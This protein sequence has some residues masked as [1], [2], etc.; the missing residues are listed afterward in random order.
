[1]NPIHKLL[2]A[3]RGEIAVRI[4]RACRE[5]DIRSVAVYSEADKQAL[6]VRMADEAVAIGPAPASESYLN[7]GRVVDAAR[8][9]H[10]DAIHPGYG[11]LSE[12][13]AFAQAVGD[14]GLIF[15]GPSPAAIHA[16][17]DKVEARSRMQARGVPVVP[18]YQDASDDASL[19]RAA[20]RIGYPVLI[21]AA[22]G[23][24]GKA[25]QV[26]REE[27]ELAE[28]AASARREAKN[29]FG[30]ERLFLEKYVSNGRHVEFQV[31]ADSHGNTL[32]LF[33][34]EC[35][36]Q[37]RHQKIIEETPSPLL[38]VDL[39]AQM[40]AAAV[41]AARA[42][43]YENAGT[44]EFIVDP[45]TRAFYFLEMNTRLQVEHPITEMVTGLDLVHWQIR[46]A[47]GE[48]L[49]FAQ[50]DLS[51]RGHAVECRVYAE[52]PANQFLPSIGCLLKVVEP[53]GP[54]IRVDSGITTGDEV[55]TY[56]DPMLAKVIVHAETRDAAIRRMR[57]ALREFVVLG[58]TTNLD[59]LQAVLTH[60]EFRAG[61]AT[62]RFIEQHMQDWE[63]ATDTFAPQA[64]I[65]AALAEVQ[66]AKG[67]QKA[68][69]SQAQDDPYT[70]WQ[71]SDG[72]R[73]GIDR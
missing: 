51:Q 37:R 34:R 20:G 62:T 63:P 17:G 41:E 19:T 32:H 38:D 15:I 59:F 40:G 46:I 14:A 50:K 73:I 71:R 33:E 39:R 68:I 9:A 4:I 35:S 45:T 70:P 56:Y 44:V 72:F 13:D 61:R 30:D 22:A 26:V 47:S 24:G 27:K 53:R 69:G 49:P 55:T 1:M 7:I 21:K 64:L 29:A 57:A 11:F 2:I 54:G 25:M 48:A 18:G 60:P 12:N 67:F 10:A 65:A 6:H 16:M 28:L 3:N 66:D 42:V 5:M 52:D 8:Q 58:V 43:G 31:L 23:G 36:I